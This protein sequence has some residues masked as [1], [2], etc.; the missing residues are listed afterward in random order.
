MRLLRA[1]LGETHSPRDL[2]SMDIL[3]PLPSSAVGRL[4]QIEAL[5]AAKRRAPLSPTVTIV[6]QGFDFSPASFEE[7]SLE[8]NS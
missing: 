4:N 8:L 2:E 7:L 3:S 5:E 1:R 6:N